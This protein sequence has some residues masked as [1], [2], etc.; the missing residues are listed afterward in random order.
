MAIDLEAL[1]KSS[2]GKVD[3]AE[4]VF[5]TIKSAAVPTATVDATFRDIS[6]DLCDADDDATH[7]LQD[8]LSLVM[9]CADREICSPDLQLS[10]FEEAMDTQ[11][12]AG[13]NALFGFLET[14]RQRM[15]AK[16]GKGQIL[17]RL[18]NELLRRLSKTEDTVFCG[19]ILI[20]L[21]LVFPLSER[22][23][24]N[25]RGEY[26]IDNV[27]TYEDTTIEE[28]SMID[29]QS[30]EA[31]K[32]TTTEATETILRGVSIDQLYTTFWSLQKFFNNPVQLISAPMILM[33]FRTAITRVI[34]A[35]EQIEDATIPSNNENGSA[36]LPTTV[37]PQ[38]A[39]SAAEVRAY[40]TPK[41][42]TSKNLLALELADLSF[43]RHILVQTL[44]V[45][46]FLLGL[47]LAQKEAWNTTGPV[48]NKSMQ[49]AY[50]LSV[51]DSEWISDL[52]AKVVRTIG[53]GTHGKQFL[54]VVETLLQRDQSWLRWK[55]DGCP[56][57]DQPS[58][59]STR[60]EA[61]S[62]R[63]SALV[64]PKRPYQHAVGNAVLSKLWTSAGKWSTPESNLCSP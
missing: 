21:S 25:L 17:L 45:L 42:L 12:I 61:A 35:L 43:R 34:E 52:R 30:S 24:V 54:E 49:I 22:S 60:T 36:D 63:I 46:D 59:E 15:T 57:Y 64:A 11:T 4:K 5:E 27:T 14:H 40:F 19:R 50:I 23:A 56:S 58:I 10:L 2:I 20:F 16:M 28:V 39:A 48:A 47:T 6:F 3:T 9:D 31:T 18:C 53:A 29:D 41:V 37:P 1:L 55:C 44:I 8:L 51:A 7:N 13:C 26:N 33:Q 62:K 38:A 32:Q